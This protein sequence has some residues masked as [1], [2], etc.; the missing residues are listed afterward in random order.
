MKS[1]DVDIQDPRV[2]SAKKKYD[3]NMPSLYEPLHGEHADQIYGGD[4]TG[5][6][7]LDSAINLEHSADKR[8]QEKGNQIHLGF[9]VEATSQ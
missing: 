4:E 3:S 9:Q 7:I 5:N 2:Y 8:S 1:G 6:P